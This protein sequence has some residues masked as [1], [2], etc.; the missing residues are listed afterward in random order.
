MA[1]L[2]IHLDVGGFEK[3]V[4]LVWLSAMLIVGVFLAKCISDNGHY[5]RSQVLPLKPMSSHCK[6][7]GLKY[8][9]Y[10]VECRC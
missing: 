1:P 5:H 3:I 8:V 2:E 9:T 10:M 6:I 4:S 7:N